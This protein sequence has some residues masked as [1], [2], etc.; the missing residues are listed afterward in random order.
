MDRHAGADTPWKVTL[1]YVLSFVMGVIGALCGGY[2]M[3]IYMDGPPVIIA[4]ACCAFL[5]CCCTFL[6]AGPG[7]WWLQSFSS[8]TRPPEIDRLTTTGPRSFSIYVTVHRVHNILNESYLS[9]FGKRVNAY[10]EVEVG[11][12]VGGYFFPQQPKNRTCVKNDAV[13]EESFHL[14]IAPTDEYIRFT[15]KDQDVF[16]DDVLGELMLHIQDEVVS[17]YF[18]QR[19]SFVFKAG[20]G[21]THDIWSK[22]MSPGTLVASFTSG[23]DF[24]EGPVSG[25]PI[26]HHNLDKKRKLEDERMTSI[27]ENLYQ[28]SL[29]YGEYGTWATQA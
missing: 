28:K 24:P 21:P 7:Y 19:K 13:F 27:K 26:F 29:G 14:V 8:Y 17:E 25:L 3:Y 20:A 1:G 9:F 18:P 16:Q 22:S 11:R 12:D 15:L 10:V 4:A 6:F 23:V 2:I 5:F